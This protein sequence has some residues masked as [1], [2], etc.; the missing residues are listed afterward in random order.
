MI[1][2]AL[3]ALRKWAKRR[4]FKRGHFFCT[5]LYYLTAHADIM[6]YPVVIEEGTQ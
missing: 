6:I 2:S 3:A 5:S 1:G 4:K